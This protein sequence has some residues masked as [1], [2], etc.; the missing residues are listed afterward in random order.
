MQG[1]EI[2][3]E[4]AVCTATLKVEAELQLEVGRVVEEILLTL[5]NLEKVGAANTCSP[6][7]SV[8]PVMQYIQ[9]GFACLGKISNVGMTG[10]FQLN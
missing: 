8:A 4:C 10:R 2:C 3:A 9:M 6:S 1:T 5:Y 7:L